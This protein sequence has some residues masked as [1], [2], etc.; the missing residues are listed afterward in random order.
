[1]FKALSPPPLGFFATGSTL[2][3]WYPVNQL[4]ARLNDHNRTVG[5]FLPTWDLRNERGQTVTSGIY[6][7]RLRAA[8]VVNV[9]RVTVVR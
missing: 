6:F 5:T 9:K 1:L 2:S 3:K 4:T 8:D 7:A